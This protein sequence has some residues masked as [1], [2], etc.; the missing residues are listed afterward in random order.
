MEAERMT[1]FNRP[2]RA[3][4]H[5]RHYSYERGM[6]WKD[7]GPRCAAGVDMSDPTSVVACMPPDGVTV[8]TNP[9]PWREEYTDAE[10]AAWQ[11]WREESMA[12]MVIVMAQMP[13]SSR[14]R[15]GGRWGE[16]G[17]FAC[18]ACNDGTVKWVRAPNNGHLHAACT[19]PGCFGVVE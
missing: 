11:A 1:A 15:K 4:H 16:S 8:V 13:G 14:D 6:N 5:C 9:C 10:R 2:L 12:R 3:T 7:A 19:T 18:P 17:S